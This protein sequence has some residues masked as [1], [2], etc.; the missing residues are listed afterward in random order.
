MLMS[1]VPMRKQDSVQA[2]LQRGSSLELPFDDGSFDALVAWRALHVFSMDDIPKVIGEMR[3]V[4]R[5]GGYIL[6]STRSDR[7]IYDENRVGK[8]V[9]LP[10]DLTLAQLEEV[11]R[12]LEIDRIELS[13]FSSDN[14]RLRDSYWVT[15]AKR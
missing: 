3:R 1:N 5:P 6:F 8:I 7:N 10:T 4:V 2:T 13:E 14:R 11:C 12:P 15:H 9:P